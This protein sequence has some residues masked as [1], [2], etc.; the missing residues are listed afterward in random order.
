MTNRASHTPIRIILSGGGTGG[1]IFPALAIAGAIRQYRPD[2]ELLF[3]GAEGKMEMERVPAAGY[4]IV[5]LPVVGFQR[6]LSWR[7]LLFPFKLWQ[8]LQ[9]A[10]GI[11]RS[12]R[13]DVG[14]GVGGYA[15]G[16]VL[17]V[18]AGSGIPFV[19]QEQNSYAGVTNR[20]LGKKA[21]QVCIAHSNAQRFFPQGK[22]QLTG[23]PVRP[24]LVALASDAGLRARARTEGL[25][26]YGL[27]SERRTLLVTGGSLGARTLNEAV[28]RMLPLLAQHPDVQV[29]WQ[30]GK[31]Y[32]DEFAPFAQEYPQVRAVP[33]LER[34]DLAYAATDLVV[35]R[36]GALTISEICLLGLPAIF[37]PS[38]NVAEDHQTA[39][40]MAL[41]EKSAARLL[42]DAEAAD[43]LSVVALE[44]LHDSATLAE[45]SANARSLGIP[46]AAERIARTVV[47]LAERNPHQR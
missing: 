29:L 11:V 30:C 2:A 26:F 42:P 12:F 25:R 14:V 36:A 31:L 19:L 45:L 44:L 6:R 47:E 17:Q 3:V 41:V 43:R 5:G 9:K 13:P 37:V 34:M 20:I 46:D 40:A 10:R 1:H 18:C 23:N 32:L 28:A 15:S 4:A 35:A 22:T 16:P 8:S 24:D 7:N 27:S 21:A 33:F 38:P 39:N